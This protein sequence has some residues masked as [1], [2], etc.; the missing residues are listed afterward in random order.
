M[1]LEQLNRTQIILLTL[2]VSFVTS[3]AT[4]IVTVTLMDQAPPAV[5]Q[6]VNRVIERT[7]ERVVPDTTAQKTNVITKEKEVTVV[8]K[9]DDLITDSIEKNK[10]RMVRLYSTLDSAAALDIPTS[11]NT[12][13]ALG[14]TDIPK[15]LVLQPEDTFVG[16]GVVVS[17][18]GLV[19]TDRSIL[20]TGTSFKAVASGGEVYIAKVMPQKVNSSVAL[21]RVQTEKPL[22]VA[23][24]F[25]N[26][27]SLKLGQTVIALG[28]R[29]R[30]NVAMG[31]IAGLS[32]R[33]VTQETENNEEGKEPVII[34]VLD[35]I[36]TNVAATMALGS[37][38]LNIFGE[39]IGIK[40][41]G[42]NKEGSYT[43]THVISEE[44]A[45]LQ[46]IPKESAPAVTP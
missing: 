2:L 33:D 35:T 38:L 20:K 5:T 17:N 34:K 8:V 41:S 6:T 39:V 21:L 14:A 29:E 13:T 19:A 23:S 44:L 7:V 26:E 22:F 4:G 45:F 16:F 37:P 10:R 24:T 15:T 46:N 11:S 18:D 36:E 40:T 25:V 9:E 31:I 32:E 12:A 1:D 43:P 27:N 28:G 30:I 42:I 3:I